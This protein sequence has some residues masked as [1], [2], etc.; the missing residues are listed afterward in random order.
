M[1]PTGHAI[2]DDIGKR[3]NPGYSCIRRLKELAELRGIMRTVDTL[4]LA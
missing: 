4:N 1:R 3:V 2:V